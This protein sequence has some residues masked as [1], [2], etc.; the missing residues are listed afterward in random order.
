VQANAFRFLPET[1]SITER[2]EIFYFKQRQV[3]QV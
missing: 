2:V 3:M 1:K